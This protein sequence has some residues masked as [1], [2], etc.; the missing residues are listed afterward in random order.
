[1]GVKY[2]KCSGCEY[3][4]GFKGD[5]VVCVLGTRAS[6]DNGCSK[7]LPDINANCET[8]YFAM[9]NDM[10]KVYCRCRKKEYKKP[11]EFCDD[12]AEEW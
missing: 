6:L 8:C 9:R 11:V 10:D 4:D 2:N 1:M 3:Y 7:F 12:Y 5:S